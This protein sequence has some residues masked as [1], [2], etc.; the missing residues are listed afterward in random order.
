MAE[1]LKAHLAFVGVRLVFFHNA[2]FDI[3]FI[4]VA[5]STT[6]LKF[7]DPLHDTLPMTLVVWPS[8]GRYKLFLM[9]KQ[10]GPPALTQLGLPDV[11]TTLAVLLS[12]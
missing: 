9:A 5:A 11:R 7:A 12:T 8:L 3:R 4:K 1:A 6:R 10:V 2:P